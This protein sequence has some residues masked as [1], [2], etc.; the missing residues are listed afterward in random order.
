MR[1]RDYLFTARSSLQRN[2][3]K[4]KSLIKSTP[5]EGLKA[6]MSELKKQKYQISN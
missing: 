5:K 2:K 3:Q 6:S 4:R 1:L